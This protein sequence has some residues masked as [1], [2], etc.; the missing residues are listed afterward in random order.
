MD[1]VTDIDLLNSG[2]RTSRFLVAS[3]TA[4]DIYAHSDN[5]TNIGD[6]ADL[7]MSNIRFR[8]RMQQTGGPAALNLRWGD[9]AQDP[10]V[11]GSGV[12]LGH[13]NSFRLDDI[14]TGPTKIY[15]GGR[16]TAAQRGSILEQSVS[17]QARYNLVGAGNI[18]NSYD[19][20]MGTG[21][22][23]A[24]VTYTIYVP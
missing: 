18:A 7:D 12:I 5:M 9:A 23:A 8:F 3:N 13:N 22:L 14:E 4:F 17:F 16:R 15:D 19:F 20:S 2:N 11:G 24:D 21:L 1:D 6:F 10:A